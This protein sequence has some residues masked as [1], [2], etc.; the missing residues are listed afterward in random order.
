MTRRQRYALLSR[1]DSKSYLLLAK[2]VWQIGNHDLRLAGDTV[3]W[4]AAL[5]PWLLGLGL[6]SL[7]SLETF[8]AVLGCESLVGCR[9]ES[10]SL[11]WYVGWS[12]AI[13]SWFCV[14]ICLALYITLSEHVSYTSLSVH[15][16]RGHHEQHGLL[17]PVLGHRGR[18]W[19]CGASSLS[20][21]SRLSQRLLLACGRAGRKPCGPRWSCR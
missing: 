10:C 21:R 9:G 20:R 14:A 11:A 16:H 19:S 3:L 2:I 13:G 4:W 17:V 8:F 18:E 7:A 12:G 6:A 15:L 5:L 1:L